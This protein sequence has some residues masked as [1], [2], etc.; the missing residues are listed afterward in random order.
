MS[1]C[2]IVYF[3]CFTTCSYL[4][5]YNLKFYPLSILWITTQRNF[6]FSQMYHS[7]IHLSN[8]C[9]TTIIFL[10]FSHWVHW[11]HSIFLSLSILSINRYSNEHLLNEWIKFTELT[12]LA[13]YKT[14]QITKFTSQI[15]KL[16]PNYKTYFNLPTLNSFHV[17]PVSLICY[18]RSHQF[19]SESI[20]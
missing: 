14:S 5:A 13:N 1:L 8:S 4:I 9:H 16:L 3:I 18:W 2:S 10:F 17:K 15:T 20:T 6:Y 11:L 12:S 7:V 19:H